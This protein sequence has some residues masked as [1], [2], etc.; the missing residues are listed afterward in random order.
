MATRV[1]VI[2]AGISGSSC[3]VVLRAAGYEV[4]VYERGRT[5]GGRLASP[6]IGER[7]VDLGAGYFTVADETFAA[8]VE[9]WH[10]DGVARPWTDTFD[11]LDGDGRSTKHGPTRW[12]AHDGLRALVR[13]LEPH[14][15]AGNE[16]LDLND[17]D[18]SITDAVV[19]AMPDPQA[20]QLAPDAF[21][22][23]EYE[24][25]IT[26]AAAWDERD[27][28]LAAAAFVN[29]DP[30]ITIIADDGSRRGDGA[31]VLVT[32]STSGLARQHLD[33][34]DDAIELVV[35]AVRRLLDI[36]APP[37]Y[38]YAHRWKFAKPAG[39][40]GDEP[41][42]LQ[43]GPGRPLG[44]CGDSWCPSGPPRTEAAWLSGRRLG[45][46]LAEHLG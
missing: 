23:V 19:L 4:D 25:V 33:S 32:H 46:A 31:P 29:D 36:G 6:T 40:H 7:R 26:V 34:P 41:F 45:L 12:V 3:A 37:R 20:A 44:V 17:L 21:D 24:P 15:R 28:D 18:G 1:A 16:I 11:V 38:T 39:T 35:Q 9:H 10:A 13:D 14:A 42:G 22:W 2:G 30:D 43:T 5:E 27:W 8:Q